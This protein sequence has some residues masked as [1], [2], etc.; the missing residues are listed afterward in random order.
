MNYSITSCSYANEADGMEF[1]GRILSEFSAFKINR[2]PK[3][4]TIFF[5]KLTLKRLPDFDGFLN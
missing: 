2:F 4:V 3:K 1:H 5:L